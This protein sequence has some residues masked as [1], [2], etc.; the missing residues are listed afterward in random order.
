MIDNTSMP[1]AKLQIAALRAIEKKDC[2]AL[3]SALKVYAPISPSYSEILLNKAVLTNRH[4][5]IPVIMEF[6]TAQTNVEQY[7]HDAVYMDRPL[8]ALQLYPHWVL[9]DAVDQTIWQHFLECAQS[10]DCQWNTVVETLRPLVEKI[11][12]ESHV[13]QTEKTAARRKM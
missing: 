7:I 5:C 10:G 4:T 11:I 2:E 6:S 13:E 8:C 12:L 1:P 3:S 9:N